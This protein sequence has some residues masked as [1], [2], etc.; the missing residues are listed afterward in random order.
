MSPPSRRASALAQAAAGLFGFC[1]AGAWGLWQVMPPG[2][3]GW[4]TQG[5][6]SPPLFGWLFA[7]PGRPRALGAL[8]AS[9]GL[10]LS[11]LAFTY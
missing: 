2:R 4:M 10:L 7:R 6:W 5:D 1:W 8:L 11:I 9:Y 3:L